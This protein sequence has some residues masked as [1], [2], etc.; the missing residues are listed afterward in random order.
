MESFDREF[1]AA[2]AEDVPARGPGKVLL[3]ST[4]DAA[5]TQIRTA[6]KK[7]GH[8]CTLVHTIE[9]ARSA[10]A[11]SP[12]DLVLISRSVGE[13][14]KA[15]NGVAFLDELRQLAPGT[16]AVVLLGKRTF[17]DS[18]LAMRAG[19]I[20]VFVL[21]MDDVDL[22][23]R[24]EAALLRSRTNQL[25]E[26]R[27][28]RLTR[29]CRRLNTAREEIG[30]QVE[31]LCKELVSA[32]EDTSEQLQDVAMTTEFR[33]LLRQELDLEELLRSALEYLL[34][35]TGPTN[36]A[37]F[38]PDD[39]EEWSLGAYVNCDCPRESISSLLDQLGEAV[40]PQMADETDLV[41]FDDTAEFA[42]WVGADVDVLAQSQV[43]AFACMHEARCMAIIVL[44]RNRTQP[45]ADGLAGTLDLLRPIF[46]AQ[47]NQ[48]IRIHHRLT[49]AW[50]K[51][52]VDEECDFHDDGADDL[53]FGG[54]A[55]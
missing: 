54:L 48:I 55:A 36:A 51:Q 33:T 13:G 17:D 43:I 24:V 2:F 40:C 34:V 26:D 47:L 53:G 16:K 30:D 41:R 8:A 14:A 44:F 50:P 11:P 19:A 6:L 4:N 21:P 29:I 28:A 20:D 22:A 5:I 25:H 3:V 52:A 7:L 12:I 15:S 1:E 42:E 23:G 49:G 27:I 18:V 46:A 35:K 32:Y 10:I 38:L 45:F 37:V 9:D 39:G 31:L